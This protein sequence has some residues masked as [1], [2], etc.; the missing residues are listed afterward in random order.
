MLFMQLHG[1]VACGVPGR[2]NMGG[3]RVV[4]YVVWRRMCCLTCDM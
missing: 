3:E 1:V 4:V 2:G